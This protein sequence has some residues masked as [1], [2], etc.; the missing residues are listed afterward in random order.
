MSQTLPTEWSR[1]VTARPS[2]VGPLAACCGVSVRYG[3]GAA[4]I[5]ALDTL[6]RYQLSDRESLDALTQLFPLARSIG[7]Q[8]A[9]AGVL[10]RADYRSIANPELVR[11]LRQH[12]LKSPSGEDLIDVLIR[13]L[14]S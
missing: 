6:A 3:S 8:R 5:R 4:Q 11:A 13:R 10:I 12:R 1:S 2:D 14:Q 7:V 9:I